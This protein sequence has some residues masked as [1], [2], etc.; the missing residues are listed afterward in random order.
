MYKF[1]TLGVRG[2]YP[3]ACLGKYLVPLSSNTFWLHEADIDIRKLGK[4]STI[5]TLE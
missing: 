3:S 1:S 4:A 2:T 5:G